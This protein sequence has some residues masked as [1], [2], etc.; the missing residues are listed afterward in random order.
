VALMFVTMVL[1]ALAIDGIFGAAQL[2]PHTRPSRSDV[3]MPIGLDYKLVLNVLG[4]LV[5]AALIGLTL[6][7]GATDPMCGMSVDRSK[8]LHLEHEGRTY[9]FCGPGCR[10]RFE[11]RARGLEPPRAARPNGT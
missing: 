9:Y 1:A 8:A 11:V 4:V 5:F 3:F 7:R 2:V 10:E 6:R